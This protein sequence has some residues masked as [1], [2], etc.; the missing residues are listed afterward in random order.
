[1]PFKKALLLSPLAINYLI[2]AL[3]SFILIAYDYL[4]RRG[5][6]A[7]LVAL[8]L[9]ACQLIAAGE[10]PYLDFLDLSQPVVYEVF[11]LPAKLQ[12]GLLQMG[13]A[14]RLEELT[15]G[16]LLALLLW[17]S[18]S[19]FYILQTGLKHTQEKDPAANIDL[20]Q[21]VLPLSITPILL[22]YFARFQIGEVQWLISL[23]LLPWLAMRYVSYRGKKFHPLPALICGAMAGLACSLEFP[24]FLA[25]I[26]LELILV[27]MH[28]QI[29]GVLSFENLGLLLSLMVV[30][31]RVSQLPVPVQ[32]AYHDWI[33]PLRYR[34]FE[35]LDEMIMGL[36]TSPELS[37][38]FYLFAAA[39][40]LYVFL[41][42]RIKALFLGT[43]LA[44]IGL[45]FFIL[46]KQGF[47][48][49]IVLA[50]AGVLFVLSTC[51]YFF[52]TNF[53]KGRA[54]VA[55][56]SVF[57]FVYSLVYWRSIER[58]FSDAIS[59]T[60]KNVTAGVVDINMFMQN[61]TN[62][63]S[64]VAIFCDQPDPAFPL[65]FNLERSPGT[66]VLNGRPLRI[67]L[68]L[69]R[70]SL[71]G[72]HLKELQDHIN[73]NLKS[74]FSSKRADFIFLH[75]AYMQEYLQ[76]NGLMDLLNNNYDKDQF[77]MFLSDNKQPREFLGYY[78]SFETYRRRDK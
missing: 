60:P 8:R 15:K 35:S 6:L 36:G 78:F 40:A 77:V 66:Y 28:K 5:D 18:L 72:A 59:P 47:T 24:Y 20:G 38:V 64:P 37:Y 43:T 74:E 10:T 21:I 22:T 61:R 68:K 4:V 34:Q 58:D 53:A 76:E 56:F 30:F 33:M 12:A 3:P 26:C 1:M 57:V 7:T 29:K 63:H 14:I 65:L 48:R 27:G 73:S 52:L 11:A 55:L 51:L 23:A 70:L 42:E 62:W 67:L 32:N 2:V 31:M 69:K 41:G 49:D 44:I 46:E 75:G 9:T 54:Q 17:S 16:I 25:P 71:L 13:L 39:F 45:G 19:I 50:M